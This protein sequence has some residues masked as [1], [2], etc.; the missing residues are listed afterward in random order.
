[1]NPLTFE[2]VIRYFQVLDELHNQT[3][4]CMINVLY[5]TGMRI[6]ELHAMKVQNIGFKAREVHIYMTKRDRSRD[7]FLDERTAMLLDYYIR[8]NRKEIERREK[9]FDHVVSKKKKQFDTMDRNELLRILGKGTDCKMS[10]AEL[11]RLLLRSEIRKLQAP[12][13]GISYR[14]IH[15]VVSEIGKRARIEKSVHPHSFR[16]NFAQLLHDS[17][18]ADITEIQTMLGHSNCGTTRGYL[19]PN[20]QRERAAFDRTFNRK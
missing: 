19:T 14:Q 13:W 10:K 4:D 8:Y 1:M 7:V 18:N 11:V 2:E 5:V 6:S 12:L 20:K 16:Y 17:G 3:Y 15:R 9:V